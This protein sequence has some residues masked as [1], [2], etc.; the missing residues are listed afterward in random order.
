M[1]A[2]EIIYY[3]FLITGIVIWEL[4]SMGAPPYSEISNDDIIGLTRF[5]AESKRLSQPDYCN[6]EI[7]EI[8]NECWR[9]DRNKRPRF[10][11]LKKQFRTMK[12][13]LEKSQH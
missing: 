3:S 6:K 8:M 9:M 5:L 13:N 11:M 7:Y 12:E 10:D 4:F 2:F 1:T